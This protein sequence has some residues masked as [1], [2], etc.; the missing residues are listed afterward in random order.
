MTKDATVYRHFRYQHDDG[1][2]K[3]WAVGIDAGAVRIRY[4]ATGQTARLRVVPSEK[5]RG[6]ARG[7]LQIRIREKVRK[8]YVE[9]GEAVVDRGRLKATPVRTQRILFWETRTPVDKHA[10][11]DRLAWAVERADADEFGYAVT[12]TPETGVTCVFNQSTWSLGYGPDG[13]LNDDGRGGGQVL[14]EH[15]PLPIL[16]LMVLARAFPGAIVF[17]NDK[18][19]AVTPLLRGDDPYFGD[20]AV[21]FDAVIEL[22]A[23]LE[24]CLGRIRLV[25]SDGAHRAV[26][27]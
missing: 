3:D 17:A 13:G 5:C 23:R 14:P 25:E 15:G 8:G 20:I 7:E 21:D 10:L 1:S 12:W 2:S 24:L 6:D 19:E 22:G 9:L 27:F 26:W 18:A 4:G 11:L 16:L